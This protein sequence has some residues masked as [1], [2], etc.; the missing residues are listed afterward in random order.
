MPALCQRPVTTHRAHRRFAIPFRHSFGTLSRPQIAALNI[1]QREFQ[2]FPRAP[3]SSPSSCRAS[4]STR[5]T[6]PILSVAF[7]T[8]PSLPLRRKSK[9]DTSTSSRPW[10]DESTSFFLART[11]RLCRSMTRLVIQEGEREKERDG[12]RRDSMELWQ[13]EDGRPPWPAIVV[14]N[15]P[16]DIRCRVTRVANAIDREK[17]ESTRAGTVL[18]FHPSIHPSRI[19]LPQQPAGS[20]VPRP[21]EERRKAEKRPLERRTK[22]SVT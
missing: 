18:A 17:G 19:G 7:V 2:P 4:I 20:I 3:S 11:S 6:S 12:Q 5:I 9:L 22:R 13:V 21:I 15:L 16:A 14:S 8:L 1:Q 10:R